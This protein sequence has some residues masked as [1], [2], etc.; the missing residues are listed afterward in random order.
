MTPVTCEPL[1]AIPID[2]AAA[3]GR[4]RPRTFFSIC[5]VETRNF[6]QIVL[7]HEATLPTRR[8]K[9][10]PHKD[11]DHEEFTCVEKVWEEAAISAKK[12]Q[13]TPDR[14]ENHLGESLL[15]PSYQ[16]LLLLDVHFPSS[17]ASSPLFSQSLQGRNGQI[18][19]KLHDGFHS[20]WQ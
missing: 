4:V 10:M 13:L 2:P 20:Q 17:S 8:E 1:R 7:Q 12:Q 3:P 9:G 6:G 18:L 14:C 15:H 19:V 5:I 16:Q 11:N